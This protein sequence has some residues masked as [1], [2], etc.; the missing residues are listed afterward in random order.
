MNDNNDINPSDILADDFVMPPGGFVLRDSQGYTTEDQ[1]MWREADAAEQAIYEAM[2]LEKR[3]ELAANETA[4]EARLR[5]Q[6]GGSFDIAPAEAASML[7]SLL[8]RQED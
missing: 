7:H 1:I 3:E 2:P 4:N 8:N 5:H 6:H